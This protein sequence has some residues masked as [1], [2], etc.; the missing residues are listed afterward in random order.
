MVTIRILSLSVC[1]L[2]CVVGTAGEALSGRAM[3]DEFLAQEVGDIERSSDLKVESLAAWQ[4]RKA[5]LRRELQEML[6]LLPEP[7]RS[8]L[9]AT[10]TRRVERPDLAVVVENIHF[11]SLPGLYVTANLYRP[12]VVQQRL[13]AVLYLCGHGNVKVNDVS[14]GNKAY[15]HHHGLWFARNGYVCLIIDTVQRGEIEGAHHGTY[16]LGMW[17]WVARGYTPAGVEAWNSIRAIDY[18]VSRPEVDASKLGVTGR[19]GGGIGSWWL[20]AL[21]DR[22]HASVPVA[23]LTDLR[24][25]I[26]DGCIERHCDCNYAVNLYRWDSHQLAALSAPKAVLFSNSDRDPLFP[27]DGV[28]RLYERL[29]AVYGLHDK[30]DRLGLTMTTGPHR[31]TQDLQVAAFLWLDRWLRGRTAKPVRDVAEKLL[32]PQEL[33][34]FKTHPADQKNTRIHDSF[35]PAAV[36]PEPPKERQAMDSLRETWLGQLRE[37]TF[38]NAPDPDE[39]SLDIRI[40]ETQRDGLLLRNLEFRSE[41]PFRLPMWVLSGAQARRPTL[42]VLNALDETGYAKTRAQLQALFPQTLAGES[43]AADGEEAASLG[44]LLKAQNWAVAYLPLRGIGPTQWSEDPRQAN[45]I[46]RRLLV[47][48]RTLGECRVYDMRRAMRALAAV[49]EL[50]EAPLWLQ[51]EREVASLAV[52]AGALEPRVARLDLWSLPSS[53][54]APSDADTLMNVLRVLD[55]PQAVSLVFPRRVILY[56]VE[57]QDFAWTE[58]VSNLYKKGDRTPLAFRRLED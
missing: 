6:G 28:L 41:G 34:V 3:L 1:I 44:R 48:G 58:A 21:D 5:E 52:Y 17:W 45:Q 31:D 19:S 57:S 40:T 24:N 35:V 15:Y 29:Q 10:V 20:G 26:L 9:R 50:A 30:T 55:L 37:K 27:M 22:V 33:K 7:P 51:A 11:Q 56:N 46:R 36:A 23:G 4:D 18:L 43:S 2:C 25:H 47:L 42:L 8:D 53:H 13:P 32:E 54:G 16:R 12:N 49:G 14:Y 39:E 38:R